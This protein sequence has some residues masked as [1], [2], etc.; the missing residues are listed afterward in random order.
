MRILLLFTFFFL[1]LIQSQ[2]VVA[3]ADLP[4]KWTVS[5]SVR[6]KS[7]G[8]DLAGATIFIRELKIGTVSDIYG[9]FSITL[10]EGIYTIQ[11]SFVGFR[12]ITRTVE[13]TK[14]SSLHLELEPSE[15]TLKE[16]EVT[17]EQANKN[18]VR[19][20]MS[21]FK[22]DMK[23]I[24]RIPSLMGEVDLIK[25]IQ[26]LPGVQSVSEGG[27]GFSVRG[28][29]SDQ[30]L[31]LLDESTVY[32]ASHL[33]GFFSVFNNDAIKD[34]KLYK[35]DIP[36][37]YGGRLSSVLDVRMKEGN[38][39]RY[40][41][42]GGIGLIASRLTIEGPII[43]D[44]MSF[45]ISGRRTYAD[46]FLALS[47]NEELRDNK[48]YFYDLNAKVNYRLN[49]N[50][51]L[52]LSG[53]F[54]R[55]VF[56]N[57][58]ARMNW[59]NGTGTVRW[60]HLFDKKLFANFTFV[61]SDYRYFLGTPDGA[62]TSFEWYSSMRDAGLKG[63]FSHY[64]NTNNTLRFGFS[65]VYHM[66]NPGLA[67]GIG[68]ESSYSEVKVPDNYSLEI[69]LYAGN[70]QRVGERFVFKY[71]LRLSMFQDIGPGTVYNYDVNFI[72][73][74]STV[75]PKGKIYQTYFGIEPRLGILFGI[76]E[77]SSIKANY[78]RTTQYLQLAQN[79]T[80]GT[81]LDI[82]FPASPNIKPQV[83]DQIAAGYFRNF[84]RN[85]IEAS[86]EVYYKYMN[87]TIDFIDFAQLLLCDT[88][89]AQVR[90]GKGW[91]YGAEFLVKLSEKKVSGWV[92]Y[93]LSR[94][95]RKVA[96]INDGDPYPAP[97]DKPNN[98]AIVVNYQFAKRWWA[99]ANWVYATGNP[100]TFPTGRAEIG[101]KIIP[102]YSDRNAYRYP[103][104]H[105]L[106]LAITFTSK[107]KENRKF[108]WDINLSIY[109]VYNRHNTWSINFVQDKEDP[110]VTYAEKI[111]LFGI[112]PSVTFNFHF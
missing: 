109:N 60:N 94:S 28:G 75:Y 32:N 80:A 36:P 68:S 99:S 6:D 22:M 100:V 31:I 81:P 51:H 71:G 53:Y 108:K 65:A 97:Y 17:S 14:N 47:D 45:I 50:N 40:E 112:V 62:A 52:F 107:E 111:Y 78:S 8:E 70:E 26:M 89:D 103:D 35:G 63:D 72:V 74:D 93:T 43:K 3:E 101:G 39:K 33:M 64:L 29:A 18:V 11:V 84:R 83:S 91:A 15:E 41:V 67:R 98:I 13:L 34:V 23:T 79:S 77:K 10:P 61:Y 86:V 87:H 49:E 105:R 102:I 19:P 90:P 56:K 66:I 2:A 96:G 92:S 4:R 59:G 24:Q 110:N 106:D 85:T 44:K 9:N 104:Y 7:D 76:N 21:T 37:M 95:I 38:S 57:P 82:W 58:F 16:V 54:G 20:E 73:I 30:N 5:G 42:T 55:D 1:I 25:A 48:L 88:I 27:S 12:T 46:L 69:G